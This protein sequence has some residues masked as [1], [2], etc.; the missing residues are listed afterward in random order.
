MGEEGLVGNEARPEVALRGRRGSCGWRWPCEMEGGLCAWHLRPGGVPGLHPGLGGVPSGTLPDLIL[1]RRGPLAVI[2][3]KEM[4][5]RV[6]ERDW[7]CLTRS[8]ASRGGGCWLVSNG[9]GDRL[10][11]MGTKTRK[12][13]CFSTRRVAR[14]PLS[15]RMDGLP[16]GPMC[17]L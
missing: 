9:D 2:T 8:V 11:Y 13:E 6:V 4:K 10:F 1:R 5:R 17:G 12:R 7:G 3:T 15:N 16:F 14:I